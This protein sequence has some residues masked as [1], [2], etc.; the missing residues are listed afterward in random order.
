MK[1]Y[2]DQGG[3]TPAQQL[4]INYVSSH[5]GIQVNVMDDYAKKVSKHVDID[6]E[7]HPSI[8]QRRKQVG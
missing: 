8:S 1:L 3:G 5:F 2:H 7:F 6:L 4:L